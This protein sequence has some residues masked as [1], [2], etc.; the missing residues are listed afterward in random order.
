MAIL[1][2]FLCALGLYLWLFVGT[3]RAAGRRNKSGFLWTVGV[4][5][6]G[7]FSPALVC[8]YPILDSEGHSMD[9][10]KDRPVA[11]AILW[12]FAV[13]FFILGVVSRIVGVITESGV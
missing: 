7:I 10:Q 2:V 11:R 13:L 4:L 3:F 8:T 12:V 1:L 6:W 9:G 5:F